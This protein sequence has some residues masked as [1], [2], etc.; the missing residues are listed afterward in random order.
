MIYRA[1][2][3]FKV[4]VTTDSYAAHHGRGVTLECGFT[5]T[6][7]VNTGSIRAALLKAEGPFPH[8]FRPVRSTKV[9]VTTDSGNEEEFHKILFIMKTVKVRDAGLYA[10][11]IS[12]G[13]AAD[14][15]YLVLKV[16]APYTK[17]DGHAVRIPGSEL[18]HLTCHARGFPAA[19]VRWP[20][21]K[22][23]PRTYIKVTSEGLLDVVGAVDE[24]VENYQTQYTC[25]FWSEN[26]EVT[27]AIIHPKLAQNSIIGND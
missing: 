18:L 22:S 15:K 10:C 2:A 16:N 6:G 7:D 12:H 11:L 23:K 8:T 9:Y 3:L 1:F 26:G 4:T 21:A 14:Y 5:Y 25:E 13:T 20:N 27:S 17:I 24:K 19:E